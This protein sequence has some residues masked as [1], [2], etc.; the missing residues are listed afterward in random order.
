VNSVAA[1]INWAFVNKYQDM[2]P[3]WGPVGYVVYKRTYARMTDSGITEEWWQTVYRCLYSLVH[4]LGARLTQNEVE[5]LYHYVF[6]LKASFSGRALWQ[7]GT[8]TIQK[9]G[10]DSLQNCWN[11][12]MDDP[13]KPFTFTMN[14]LML[15]GGVG[16]NLT[17]EYVYS[18]PFVKFDPEI[19]WV[20]EHDV[21]FIIPDNREGWVE[22]LGRML[23]CFFITGKRFHFSA[24]CIR[25]K[26]ARINGFG[27]VASGP[28]ELCEGLLNIAKIIS[29]RYGKKLRP[30]DVLDIQNILGSIVVA[31]NVRRSA[32]IA[33]GSVLDG[34]FLNS[35]AWGRAPIPAWRAM[36]NNSVDVSDIRAIPE[37]FWR[38]YT[39]RDKNDQ[40]V[41]ECFG[42]VNIYNA[43]RYGRLA[44][45]IDHRPDYGV[46][47]FNPC[48][49][50]PLESYE[51]C[52]LAELYLPNLGD[53]DDFRIA[54]SLL[55][56][57]CKTISNHSYSDK[58]TD[59]VVKRNQRIGIGVTGFLQAPWLMD[60]RI[61][62][63]VYRHLEH[64]DKQYSREIGANVS[65]KLT[66][67]K[68]SGTLSLL[69]GVTPGVHPAYSPYYIRRVRFASDDPLV[70][71][72]IN[73]GFDVEP[74]MT[75]DGGRDH[76]TMVASFPCQTEA[77]TAKELSAVQQ[78]EIQKFL[79]TN[80][81]D[82]SVSVT[83]YFK[84]EELPE[85]RRWLDK[86][87]DE[88]VKS[89]SFLR[90]S[91]HGFLQA[92]LEEISEQT[93]RALISKSKPITS[94][95]DRQLREL[96]ETSECVSGACPV[97]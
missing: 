60:A 58:R 56:K 53:E 91:K 29:S 41:S 25:D 61:F 86:N 50:I 84:D 13:I 88:S 57:A 68:P 81:A 1:G 5:Q 87:Y 19:K 23:E 49:E 70:Q 85:I 21:D 51:A 62:N 9:V 80:W 31:G 22:T 10:M 11:V 16:Y 24:V 95:I 96:V 94:V 8:K 52:N 36:S 89:V 7:L 44:D 3:P 18:M 33:I 92:P 55:Y 38:N 73:H 14:Q 15:G 48:A 17:P 66:T 82:N 6:N 32:Q 64:L 90:H 20:D 46:C 63:N 77:I 59:E 2:V 28:T 78:L 72:C 83:V 34:D 35:K 76:R 54:A 27:G 67:V 4:D 79:Q 12:A 37:L 45:G 74:Q 43:R 30:I 39:D 47:G 69:A 93:Y 65:I 71:T 26:G 42:L 97:K 40:A 75:L